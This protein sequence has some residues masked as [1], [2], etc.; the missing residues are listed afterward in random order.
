M[1]LE[2]SPDSGK[3]IIWLMSQS[4]SLSA[5]GVSLAI[6]DIASGRLTELDDGGLAYNEN[7]S[8]ASSNAFA[9][10]SGCGRTMSEGKSISLF[11]LKKGLS[12]KTLDI[13]DRMPTT[14]CYSTDGKNLPLPR[15]LRSKMMMTWLLDTCNFKRAADLHVC[16]RQS[17]CPYKRLRIPF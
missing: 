17:D 3:I 16:E 12:P 13:Q 10:I 1:D 14:P 5:D 9:F 11:D 15:S 4:G 8:F 6:Y 2:P 7:V